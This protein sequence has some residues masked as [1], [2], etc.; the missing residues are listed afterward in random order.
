MANAQ[1]E[2]SKKARA[3]SSTEY[4]KKVREFGKT[5]TA[6]LLDHPNPPHYVPLLKEVIEQTG[7]NTA[8]LKYL[9]DLYAQSKPKN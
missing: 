6:D 2:R 8:A 5:F 7:S 1:T 3:N 4:R 9:L